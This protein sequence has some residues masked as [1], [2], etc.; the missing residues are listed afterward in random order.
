MTFIIVTHDQEE[1]MTMADRIGVMDRGRLV[2]VATP[3]EIYEQPNSRWVA[4]FVGD[5]NLFEGE[6]ARSERRTRRASTTRGGR[7]RASRSRAQT[8]S[9]GAPVCGRGPA[10]EG[11]AVAPRPAGRHAQRSTA[12]AGDVADIGYLGDSSVYKVR[13]DDGAVR[14]SA[15]IANTARLDQRRRISVGPSAWL[16]LVHARRPAWCWKQMSARRM[17]ARSRRGY[18]RASR[19]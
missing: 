7:R 9:Q 12:L 18:R 8:R 11:Q 4:E 5:V 16:T 17:L 14:A 10:R 13:L 6:V 19:A 15:S 2:Q 3:R 1:A